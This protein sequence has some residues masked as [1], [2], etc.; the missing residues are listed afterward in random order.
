[1]DIARVAGGA[2]LLLFAIGCFMTFPD[3]LTTDVIT[4]CVVGGIF[5][6]L[7]VLLLA[8]G[9]KKCTTMAVLGAIL[10][11]VSIFAVIG[12]PDLAVKCIVCGLFA[13]LGV[14]LLALGF[15]CDLM[16]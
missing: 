4:K 3:G 12:I 6:G 7:G 15:K 5:A 16:K 1:M 14:L 8:C 11:V 9:L 13:G 2:V 10:L